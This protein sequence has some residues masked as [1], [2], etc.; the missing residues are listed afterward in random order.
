MHKQVIEEIYNRPQ[1]YVSWRK[2]NL[3][4]LKNI[5]INT[6]STSWKT[7]DELY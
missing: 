6:L 1:V 5:D 3:N 2:N 7:Y 4:D